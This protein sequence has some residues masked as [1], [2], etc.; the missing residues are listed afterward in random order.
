MKTKNSSKLRM[1]R[2]GI[3]LTLGW[4]W[5][6]DGALQLQH[7]MFTSAFA[8]QVIT[9]ASVG[10]PQIV[11]GAMHF[12]VHIFLM[13][14]AIYNTII[15]A[16]QLGLGALILWRRTARLGLLLS[17]FWGLFVWYIGE[18]LGGVLSGQ[19][20][21]LMGAPGAALLYVVLALAVFPKDTERSRDRDS[22]A[23]WLAFVWAFL[24]IGGAIYQ[25]LPG[26]NSAASIGAM[27]A[28]NASGAPG[29]LERI[30][31]HVANTIHG[32]TATGTQGTAY[33]FI[34][35]LAI[36]QIAIGVGVLSHRSTRVVA[37]SVGIGVSI[38]FWVVGQS[39]GEYFSGL[40]TDPSTAPLFILLG[41]AILG[42]SQL[43]QELSKIYA[44]VESIFI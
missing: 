17:V 18:G 19:T 27:I 1:T 26:Q 9:P 44:K 37:L 23:P 15:A 28:G 21:L 33:W 39:L 12:F 22:P 41:L 14:P 43:D 36:F 38:V 30:D 6:L 7:Q 13:H 3:Q 42:Q 34:L 10:Q 5:F 2:R 35:F 32:F 31:M 25:L 11:G 4:L 8:T 29:W 16:I 40:A 20:S 24:W